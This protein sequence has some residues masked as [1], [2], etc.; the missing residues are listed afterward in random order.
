MVNWRTGETHP[1]V[2]NSSP[3]FTFHHANAFEKD[4]CLVVDYCK[5]EQADGIMNALDLNAMRAEGI[6]L[7][8]GWFA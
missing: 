4:G 8:V 2:F 1:V 3:F 6:K 7:Q 5:I